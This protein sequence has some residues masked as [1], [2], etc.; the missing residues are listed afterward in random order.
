MEIPRISRE[1]Q[2]KMANDAFAGKKVTSIVSAHDGMLVTIEFDS[3]EVMIID[4]P[5]HIALGLKEL[6]NGAQKA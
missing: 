5:R 3:G 1:D 6:P 2:I 4:N